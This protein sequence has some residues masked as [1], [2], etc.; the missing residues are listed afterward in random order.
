[1]P[2]QSTVQGM[3]SLATDL[4]L[5]GTFFFF[6]LRIYNC[7]DCVI[8]HCNLLSRRRDQS[9]ACRC[10]GICSSGQLPL[11]GDGGKCPIVG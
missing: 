5:C 1:L 8:L 3:S 2:A 9:C 10:L 11:D 7:Q 4:G 6:L